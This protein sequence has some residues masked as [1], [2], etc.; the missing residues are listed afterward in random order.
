MELALAGLPYDVIAER[1]GYANKGGAWKAVERGLRDTMRPAG[2]DLRALMLYRLDAMLLAAW[3][4]AR[5]GDLKAIAQVVRIEE[6][7]AALTGLNAAEKIEHSGSI[8]VTIVRE[9]SDDD[10][11]DAAVLAGE[12]P[13]VG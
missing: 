11:H 3:A 4:K 7:R 9:R 12:G 10:E 1:L 6:R 13:R 8:N 2:D 5:A